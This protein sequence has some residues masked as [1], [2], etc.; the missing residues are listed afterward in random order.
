[1]KKNI[2]NTAVSQYLD[3]NID[4]IRSL[5]IKDLDKVAKQI[6]MQIPSI[7]KHSANTKSLESKENQANSLPE[8][9]S[10]INAKDND[11]LVDSSINPWRL[12]EAYKVVEAEKVLVAE[13]EKKVN[14]KKKFYS[15]LNE[16]LQAKEKNHQVVKAENERFC[17]SQALEFEKWRNEQKKLV[18][19]DREK[20]L[21]LK[22]M[23][24]E[25]ITS[26][27]QR[28]QMLK[29][30]T[31]KEERQTLINAKKS[32]QQ[33]EEQKR[34]KKLQERTK[35]RSIK[36]EN[37]QR[38]SER[39]KI[40]KKEEEMDAKLMADMKRK[41]DKEEEDRIREVNR[42]L[43]K[44]ALLADIGKDAIKKKEKY[45][46][47]IDEKVKREVEV[48]DREARKKDLRKKKEQELKQKQI[49]ET[50]EKLL[51]EKRLNKLAQE[52]ADEDYYAQ[53][54]REQKAYFSQE[55]A[56]KK[57]S[58]ETQRL[59]CVKIKKQ[60]EEQEKKKKEIEEM[61]F[62]EKKINKEV[63]RSFNYN[64]LSCMIF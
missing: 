27:E 13:T 5:S 24:Q 28:N 4:I 47:I 31:Q 6:S 44:C 45:D 38:K 39:E 54:S 9:S 52:K 29:K 17:K 55:E 58:A 23:R 62:D 19:L 36:Q 60:I 59:Y 56:K 40:Q 3:N 35:L 7:I 2:I 33:E 53:S 41:L 8:K 15:I 25:E 42:R 1:M 11:N 12:I 46:S 14:D 49:N 16:Q 30:Q 51:N 63:N 20:M 64:I 26:T 22:K 21:A 34:D 61:S 37:D 50:N 32:L 43:E 18:E 48:K 57:K 10:N